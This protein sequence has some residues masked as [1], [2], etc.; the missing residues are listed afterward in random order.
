MTPDDDTKQRRRWKAALETGADCLTVEELG[1]WMDGLFSDAEESRASAHLAGCARC[2]TELALFQE[3]ERTTPQPKDQPAVSWIVAE[4]KRRSSESA[5]ATGE[6]SRSAPSS[7]R[8]ALSPRGLAGRRISAAALSLAAMVIAVAVGLSVRTSREP[9]LI[10]D[11]IPTALRSQGVVGLAPIG[12]LMQ[13]PTELRWQPLPG[14]ARYSIKLMEVDRSEFWQASAEGT[15]V[16]LPAAVR[17]KVVPGKTL[18]WQVT[19]LDAAGKALGSSPLE[20][21]RLSASPKSDP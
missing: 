6:V 2:Q 1:R 12:D 20:R 7:A 9:G 16:L 21:F 18:L 11:G 8:R 5:R 10:S 3:L 13:S 15:V 17:E 14:A 19:A 4:L